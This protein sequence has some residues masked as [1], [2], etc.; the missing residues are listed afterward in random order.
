[1][2]VENGGLTDQNIAKKFH[3][4]RTIY[5]EGNGST[6]VAWLCKLHCEGKRSF[7]LG[8]ILYCGVRISQYLA[9]WV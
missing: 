2:L 1:M 7:L 9:M 4:K 6:Q 8:Q 3:L 5:D